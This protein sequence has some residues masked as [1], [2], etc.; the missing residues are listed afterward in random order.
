MFAMAHDNSH[1]DIFKTSLRLMR[2]GMYFQRILN[3]KWLFSCKNNYINYC[4]THIL[5]SSGEYA[6]AH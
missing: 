2:F 1:K 3:I 4:C 5:R 6:I